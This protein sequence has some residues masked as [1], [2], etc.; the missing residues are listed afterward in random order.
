[1]SAT[2]RKLTPPPSTPPHA[3]GRPA[4]GNPLDD[5]HMPAAGHT[6]YGVVDPSTPPPLVLPPATAVA[7]A[8]NLSTTPKA[9]AI[10]NPQSA[11]SPSPRPIVDTTPNGEPAGDPSPAPSVDTTANGSTAQVTS[12]PPPNA[13]T[14]AGP[15][16]AAGY[17]RDGW[18]RLRALADCYDEAQRT[19]IA[20][21]NRLRQFP[22]LAVLVEEPENAEK[23]FAKALRA[24]Y[25][26]TVPE[27]VRDWQKAQHGIGEH[28]L[29][30]LL[31]HLGHPVVAIPHHWEGSGAARTLVVDLPYARTLRQL[32][33]YCGHGDPARRRT[34]NVV[35]LF[36]AGN[37]KLKMLAHLIAE[38]AIKQP[39]RRWTPDLGA[40]WATDPA[41]QSRAGSHAPFGG[42]EPLDDA[43]MA[44]AGQESRGVVDPSAPIA[45]PSAEAASAQEREV[46]R[47]RAAYETARDRYTDR[48]HATPCVRCGPSGR[49]AE[50]GSSWSLAHQHAAA[51]RFVA[52]TILADLWRAAS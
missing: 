5:A 20:L 40:H 52:K 32:W 16:T 3:K 50:P 29:A 11:S 17:D 15:S 12:T 51:L 30:R 22:A 18:L 37:P 7:A 1:M 43:H 42:G 38:S 8:G 6:P 45:E 26:R 2:A 25:R 9:R 13:Y 44:S 24:E 39:G 46:W 21:A 28:L 33:A 34:A 23:G 14:E 36:A 47:Y 41:A 4:A 10:P 48:T 49:P 27:P 31:G 19:R 35:D